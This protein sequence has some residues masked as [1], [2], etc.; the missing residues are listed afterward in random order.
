MGELAIPWRFSTSELLTTWVWT[1]SHFHATVVAEPAAFAWELGDLVT[2]TDGYPRLVAE[3][4]TRRFAEAEQEIREAVG[5]S[6]PPTLGYRDYAGPLATTFRLATGR[7]VDLG[8]FEGQRV[9]V[10]VGEPGRAPSRYIGVARIVHHHVEL[11][12]DNG[13][14]LRIQPSH[15]LD[16]VRETGG[17]SRSVDERGYTGA[18]RIYR[19]THRPGCTGHPGFLPGTVDHHAGVCPIHELTRSTA[20]PVPRRPRR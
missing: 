19:D 12:P 10:T 7:R 15:I 3:G 4:R 2:S 14:T 17:G 16:I 13:R 6:Y 9:L 20:P 18:G 1:T 8:E 11:R 5:K